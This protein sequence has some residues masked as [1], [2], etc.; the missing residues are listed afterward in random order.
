[1]IALG[2]RKKTNVWV[3]GMGVTR[4]PSTGGTLV[5]HVG[6]ILTSCDASEVFGIA[7]LRVHRVEKSGRGI[8]RA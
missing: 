6:R 4:Y 7:V 1:M 5:N 3:K 8:H 2:R